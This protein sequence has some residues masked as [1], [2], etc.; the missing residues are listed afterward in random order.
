MPHQ[1]HRASRESH[2]HT[3][4]CLILCVQG[5]PYSHQLVAPTST[6]LPQR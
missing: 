1:E 2:N 6:A 3:H 4:G 5:L